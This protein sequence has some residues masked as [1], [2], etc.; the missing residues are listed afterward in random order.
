MLGF[1][2]LNNLRQMQKAAEA[3][4]ATAEY[5]GVRVTLNGK[6]E[7][8]EVKINPALDQARQETLL[9]D[10]FNDAAREVQMALAK[11]LSG[12]LG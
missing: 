10:C 11:K 3:E 2:Q 9:R 12:L 8:L 5:D 7:T 6:L 1:K 4:T